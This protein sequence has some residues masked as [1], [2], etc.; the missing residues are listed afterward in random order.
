[1]PGKKYRVWPLLEVGPGGTV[2]VAV[3]PPYEVVV[4]VFADST[5]PLIVGGSPVVTICPLAV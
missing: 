1:M 5:Q 3:S 2:Q 4:V